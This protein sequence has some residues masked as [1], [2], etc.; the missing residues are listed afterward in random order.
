VV[1]N[2]AIA[3]ALLAGTCLTIVAWRFAGARIE[4]LSPRRR[5]LAL[6]LLRFAPFLTSV[7]G[8]VAALAAFLRFE[9]RGTL[10]TPGVLLSICAAA[11]LFGIASGI[12]RG[13]RAWHN[14]SR[15]VRRWSG[16]QLTRHDK[17]S[18]STVDTAY[19]IVAVVGIWKPRLYISSRV[20]E[21]CDQG[22][23]DAMV[24]HE[25]AHIE[26]RDNVT[27]LGFLCAPLAPIGRRTFSELESQWIRASEEAADDWA[28]MR[29][30]TSL[31]LASALT[32][33]ARLACNHDTPV[34]HASA[35][36]SG[37]AVERRIRRL[38]TESPAP[39]Q[40]NRGWLTAAL[41]MT[42]IAAAILALQPQ[43]PVYE[44]A[45]F[46]MRHLP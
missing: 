29:A 15:V 31:A 19:P 39:V 1:T 40:K 43:R 2:A 37:S 10:E 35:I 26:A 13:V 5:A 14:A 22:E 24:A 16:R 33:V 41:T 12:V 3:V 46:C 30:D 45:E 4:R 17:L 21:S 42:A 8:G 6:A 38:L 36:L 20:V 23:L 9:P 25:C 11:G 44:L 32:K 28:R 7:V 18:I 34:I 27:R